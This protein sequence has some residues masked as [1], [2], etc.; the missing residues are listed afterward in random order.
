LGSLHPGETLEEVR[1]LTGFA[2]AAPAEIPATPPLDPET[3]GL[4][5]G[6]VREKL[7]QT[8]PQFAARLTR[9]EG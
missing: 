7:A 3:R 8:Y 5:Y 2:F 4:L 9:S 1:R 6:P